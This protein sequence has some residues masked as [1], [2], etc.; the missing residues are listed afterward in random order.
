MEIFLSLVH[1]L[2][3]NAGTNLLPTAA[4]NNITLPHN[5]F[6][7]SIPATGLL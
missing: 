4:D 2:E 1:L 5:G 6:Y 7:P 3:P